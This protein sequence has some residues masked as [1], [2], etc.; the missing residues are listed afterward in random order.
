MLIAYKRDELGRKDQTIWEDIR[1]FGYISESIRN[2]PIHTV[3]EGEIRK[4]L[5]KDYLSQAPKQDALKKR[6]S[7]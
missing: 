3:T 6:S 7:S 1:H 4:W 2:K 5:V